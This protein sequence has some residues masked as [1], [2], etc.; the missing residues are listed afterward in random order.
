MS[1][2]QMTL[3][4]MI[5]FAFS[6]CNLLA[7][8]VISLRFVHPEKQFS[9]IFLIDL[10]IIIFLS[11]MHFEKQKLPNKVTDSGIKI[12]SSDKQFEKL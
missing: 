6:Q 9:P 12:S 11:D 8:N 4:E 7:R 2:L 10:G 1:I 5:Q 3:L